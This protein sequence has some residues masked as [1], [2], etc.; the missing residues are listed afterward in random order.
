M[1]VLEQSFKKNNEFIYEN[2]PL[3]KYYNLDG[4]N[5]IFLTTDVDWA[6]DFCVEHVINLVKKY[7]LKINIFATHASD[8]LLSKS[9]TFEVGLH[10]DFTRDNFIWDE[11]FKKLKELYPEAHG[12][13][14]HRNVFGQNVSDLYTKYN[15]K[16][17]VSTFLWNHSYCVGHKDYNGL[18]R[19]SYMWED[20]IHLDM[21]YDFS[22][23]NVNLCTP[24]L[25]ILN[26]HP[27]LIYLNC[28]N[29]NE[30]RSV[31]S[32]YKDLTSAKES[33]INPYINQGYGICSFWE[34]I[35][36]YISSNNI[37]THH[38]MELL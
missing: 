8:I 33:D 29:D 7:N 14:G 38:F 17:D 11:K 37:Q 27:I 18:L 2:D 15:I 36:S 6:P 31:T 30:R 20:G 5:H 34:E 19:M 16:Y 26:V 32:K 35:L 24:G 9:N 22:W 10:P 25:K 13:R 1:T 4:L 12:A 28:I 23:S 21:G 3:K